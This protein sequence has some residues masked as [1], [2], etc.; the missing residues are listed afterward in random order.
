MQKSRKPVNGIFTGLISRYNLSDDD[1][2]LATNIINGILR[3]RQSL[4][5][6]LQNLC[7]QPLTKLKPFVHEALTVG[8]YQIF[9]LD[10]IPESAAV[11]ESVKALQAA[12]LPKQLQG[13]VNGVLRNSIR[14]RDELQALLEGS[15]QPILNHPQWLTK[16]WEKRFGLEETIS[17]CRQNNAQPPLTL[18]AN[19]CITERDELLKTLVNAGISARKGKY[20]ED[21]L[22][23]DNYHGRVSRLPGYPEGAFQIQDQGAQLLAGLLGPMT[24][25]GAYLDGCAGMGGKTSVIHQLCQP[26]QARVTA[27]EPE[28]ERQGKFRENMARLHAE[29]RIHLFPGSL[30]DFSADCR[31]RFHGILVDAPCS[32]TGVTGRHPDIRW[33]RRPEDLPGYQQ[34]QLDLLQTAAPLL[35]PQGILVYATCS[36]EEEENQEVIK[37]FL[38]ANENFS[39]EDCT[40]HLPP[41]ARALIKKGCFAPLPGP[42]IDGFFG[43][44]LVRK[45]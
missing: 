35:R 8:L 40:E 27:V 43:A 34:T 32:G 30:Q 13:F 18:Q 41:A 37:Y 33:N 9:F 21:A 25:Q 44:R 39:L 4:D 26:V 20:S 1:R 22:I 38:A 6:I 14:K 7:T 3:L 2:Q 24:P 5:F 19:R 10:R 29:Q 15:A 31:T 45:Y 23:L 12:H 16:R 28:K 42:E 11:N 36:L 17:I